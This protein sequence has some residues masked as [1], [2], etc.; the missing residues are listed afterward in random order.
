M[1][2]RQGTLRDQS[3][4]HAAILKSTVF[5][6][7]HAGNRFRALRTATIALGCVPLSM[8]PGTGRFRAVQL[9]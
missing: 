8:G 7:G 4:F 1:A 5:G 9:P 2:L 3:R 6:S